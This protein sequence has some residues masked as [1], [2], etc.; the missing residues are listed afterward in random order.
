MDKMKV[1]RVQC[2]SAV[3]LISLMS[4][5]LFSSQVFASETATSETATS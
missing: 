3:L 2:F 1:K 5:N 4:G